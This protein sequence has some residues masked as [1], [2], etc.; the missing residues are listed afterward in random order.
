MSA[1]TMKPHQDVAAELQRI[2]AAIRKARDAVAAGATIDI[3]P[4]EPQVTQLCGRL[5]GLPADTGA[6]LKPE[7]AALIA[8][9]GELAELIQA[10]LAALRKRASAAGGAPSAEPSRG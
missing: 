10:R 2:A 5:A 7:V 9:F 6:A 8:D 4:L 1:G 3:A